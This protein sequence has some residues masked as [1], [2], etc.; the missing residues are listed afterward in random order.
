[1]RR[2]ILALCIISLVLIA[3]APAVFGYRAVFIHLGRQTISILTTGPTFVHHPWPLGGWELGHYEPDE[4]QGYFIPTVQLAGAVPRVTITWPAIFLAALVFTFLAVR[5]AN[6][7]QTPAFPVATSGKAE[8]I[9]GSTTEG[10][11]R[12]DP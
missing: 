5:W 8:T 1:M 12:A 9:P 10:P 7:P 2:A 3:F 11:R 6:L 4:F